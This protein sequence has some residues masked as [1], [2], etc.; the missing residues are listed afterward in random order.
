MQPGTSRNTKRFAPYEIRA[1]LGRGGMGEVYRAWDPRLH[2]AARVGHAADA[3]GMMPNVGA[4]I[5][6]AATWLEVFIGRPLD[7]LVNDVVVQPD[8]MLW[9]AF[10]NLRAARNSFVHEGVARIGQEPV[11]KVVAAQLIGRARDIT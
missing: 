3:Q 10:K 2:R 9:E 8:L 4:A 6:L 11:T 5:T 1:P 7:T